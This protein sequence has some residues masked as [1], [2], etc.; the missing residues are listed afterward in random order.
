MGI[1]AIIALVIV[2]TSIWAA[3][4]STKYDWSS[5]AH[6]THPEWH[7]AGESP[8]TWL[9]VCIVMWPAF[10]PGYFWDRKYAPRR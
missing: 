3:E 9:L 5:W 8:G 7:S 2:G 4:D 10:F 1:G 6:P